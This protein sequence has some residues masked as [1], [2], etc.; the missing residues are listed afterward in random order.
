MAQK[1]DKK[2]PSGTADPPPECVTIG[3]TA[4]DTV[5][6]TIWE[7]PEIQLP[8]QY[9][10]SVREMELVEKNKTDV[11]NAMSGDARSELSPRKE[12]SKEQRKAF[13]VWYRQHVSGLFKSEQVDAAV[14]K[15]MGN[16]IGTI[17]RW[18]MQFG[19]AKRLENLKKEE[20][21]ED[22]ILLYAKNEAVEHDSLDVVLRYL[23][24]IRSLAAADIQPHHVSTMMKLVEFSQKNKEKMD[25]PGQTMSAAGVSLTIQQN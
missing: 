24:Y 3:S 19:W 7:L 14:A 13:Q 22:K 5:E 17:R 11:G 25:P 20:K 9:V 2:T 15:A 21:A 8:G 4:V 18:K 1:R 16:E 12:E 10:P 6:D 23:A